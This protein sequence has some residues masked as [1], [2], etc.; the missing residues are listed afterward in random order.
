[1][2]KDGIIALIRLVAMAARDTTP[3]LAWVMLRLAWL[4]TDLALRLTLLT[5][6]LAR[7][8]TFLI[9]ALARLVAVRTLLRAL[10]FARL[11]ADFALV[12][13]LRSL[14]LALADFFALAFLGMDTVSLVCCTASG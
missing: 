12:F 1:M 6:L 11:A 13:R 7:A 3:D 4:L 5:A 8:L 14:L 2:G 9:E 10:D